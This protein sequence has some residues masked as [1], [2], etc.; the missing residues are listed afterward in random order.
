MQQQLNT[1]AIKQ[2]DRVITAGY[3]FIVS[4]MIPPHHKKAWNEGR[5]KQILLE[6]ARIREGV[7]L[8][9]MTYTTFH[10]AVLYHLAMIKLE[11]QKKIGELPKW[12]QFKKRIQRNQDIALRTLVQDLETFYSSIGPEGMSHYERVFNQLHN[13]T[14]QMPEIKAAESGEEQVPPPAMQ[15]PGNPVEPMVH[16]RAIV[17]Q[18]QDLKKDIAE[19]DKV[20]HDS[21]TSRLA[22]N[23]ELKKIRQLEKRYAALSRN[24]KELEDLHGPLPED[25]QTEPELPIDVQLQKQ[26]ELIA[27]I[28]DEVLKMEQ[29][30]RGKKYT[31]DDVKKTTQ[32]H[33]DLQAARF[34]LEVLERQVPGSTVEYNPLA[35]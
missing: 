16:M 26:R 29:I 27:H 25:Q 23:A 22:R 14:N 1:N 33:K 18:V 5:V 21:T 34:R 31:R 6:P 3:D 11:L 28:E 13:Q 19:S 35:T 12:W 7:S 4:K 17:Q 30:L 24:L 32:L 20:I 15:P 2:R 8:G 9:L 10:F